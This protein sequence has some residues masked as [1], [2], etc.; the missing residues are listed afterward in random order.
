MG[1][2]VS[3]ALG[4]VQTCIPNVHLS[5]QIRHAG[6]D[7]EMGLG[8]CSPSI[9]P[10]RGKSIRGVKWRR[11]QPP[12]TTTQS[13][14]VISRLSGEPH[15]SRCQCYG[16]RPQVTIAADWHSGF[17]Y[18]FVELPSLLQVA[19]GCMLMSQEDVD[20]GY[21]LA[22]SVNSKSLSD[23]WRNWDCREK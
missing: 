8:R 19:V 23:N 9:V 5:V 13:R 14:P 22:I 3:R 21:S 7:S 12:G 2:G 6:M 18:N 17:K 20:V 11:E 1:T 15:R 10:V 16:Q 4:G